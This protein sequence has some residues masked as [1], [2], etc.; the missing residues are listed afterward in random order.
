MSENRHDVCIWQRPFSEDSFR[1][2]ACHVA[3]DQ[4]SHDQ[5]PRERKKRLRQLNMSFF[6]RLCCLGASICPFCPGLSS[7]FSSFLSFTPTQNEMVKNIRKI[8]CIA[9]LPMAMHNH[10]SLSLSQPRRLPSISLLHSCCFFYYCFKPTG[11]CRSY[12]LVVTVTEAFK[13]CW[14]N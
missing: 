11:F 13:A 6:V 8:L 9:H 7:R 12:V 2:S 10:L 4:F 3:A 1:Q 5:T 14:S